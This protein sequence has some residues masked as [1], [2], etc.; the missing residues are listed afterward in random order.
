MEDN[1]YQGKQSKA[2]LASV[3]N[4]FCKKIT[5]AGYI[6]GVYASLSWFNNKIGK[7]TAKHTKWVAQ[8]YK[9]YN[10]Q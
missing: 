4:A 5:N 2:T 1:T 8:Y 6:A 3:C 9:K 7:I 10:I